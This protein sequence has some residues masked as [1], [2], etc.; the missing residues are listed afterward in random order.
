MQSFH[1]KKINFPY[2]SIMRQYRSNSSMSRTPSSLL[3]II[4]GLLIILWIWWAYNNYSSPSPVAQATGVS[5]APGASWSEVIVLDARQKEI[6]IL[7]AMPLGADIEKVSVKK[8]EWV[9][10][11]QNKSFTLIVEKLGEV[12]YIGTVTWSGTLEWKS[13][14][15]WL[16]STNATNIALRNFSLRTYS[17][18][19]VILAQ[20][21]QAS[22]VYVLSGATTI[23]VKDASATLSAGK[24]LTIVNGDLSN[25]K[26]SII[27]KIEAI[28]DGMKQDAFFLSHKWN[29][30]LANQIQ[31]TATGTKS[32][33]LLSGSSTW[34]L[35]SSQARHIE[36]TTPWDEQR[37]NSLKFDIEGNI[38]D[39]LVTRVTINDRDAAVSPVDK[40][41]VYKDFTVSADVTNIVYKAYDTQKN[42][43]EK[44]ALTVYVDRN[45]I[46]QSTA[47]TVTTYPISDANFRIVAPSENP[48]KTTEDVVQIQGTVPADLV[49]TISVNGFQL[50]KFKPYSSTW[51]YFANK[52][53]KTMN[54][55]INEYTIQYFGADGKI[56]STG[57]FIIVKEGKNTSENETLIQ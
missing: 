21:A 17:G 35:L 5:V 16:V 20:H 36:I 19:I 40:T 47:P 24:K 53:Y 32:N 55:G 50:T 8:W 37:M 49:K 46:S 42:I 2:C 39:P 1:E 10:S 44:W 25:P 15:G 13:W 31:A 34:K 30:V 11:T 29:I 9:L 27:D 41:F 4:V 6:P 56:L 12:R 54:D 33:T 3:K 7:S 28:D 18:S 48:Y 22:S 45:K 38:L 23:R 52:D 14:R 57:K 51:Y 26:V 43:L